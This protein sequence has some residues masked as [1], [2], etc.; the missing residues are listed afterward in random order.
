ML[1]VCDEDKENMP[2][3][4]SPYSNKEKPLCRICLD[5]ETIDNEFEKDVCHCSAKMPAHIDCLLKW[6]SKKCQ[7]TAGDKAIL[8]DFQELICD[9]CKKE[10]PSTI[11][12]KGIDVPI[13]GWDVI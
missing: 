6:M 1:T 7:K 3:L 10:L 8:F 5:Y 13:I 12:R 2:L 9:I 11:R 4:N